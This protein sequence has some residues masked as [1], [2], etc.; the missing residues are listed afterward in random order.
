[1]CLSLT[2]LPGLPRQGPHLGYLRQSQATAHVDAGLCPSDPMQFTLLLLG[3]SVLLRWLRP[4]AGDPR[5]GGCGGVCVGGSVSIQFTLCPVLPPG[6][7]L[8]LCS[9]CLHTC[10][11]S[12]ATPLTEMSMKW[13]CFVCL[14]VFSCF[15]LCP[16][17]CWHWPQGR[18]QE[19][20]QETPKPL[21]SRCP[22]IS[23]M[24]PPTP[25]E[26]CLNFVPL[27]CLSLK[28][29]AQTP[30]QGCIS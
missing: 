25:L 10:A 24:V 2:L 29:G 4:G 6:R 17:R 18:C 8:T 19:V 26:R 27:E 13:F 12:R 14:S 7:S 22:S 30:G 28:Y 11:P 3:A 23:T 5:G 21:Q 16:H 9:S 20:C 1:M 15:S